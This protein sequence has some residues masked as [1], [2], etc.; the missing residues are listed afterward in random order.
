[1]TQ[2][3][4]GGDLPNGR[5]CSR[6]G[7]RVDGDDGH[8]EA[9]L[10]LFPAVAGAAGGAGLRHGQFDGVELAVDVGDGL[11]RRVRLVEALAEDLDEQDLRR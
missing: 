5:V 8:D 2:A 6:F 9:G 4:G 7:G 10:L 3:L 1:M 11:R